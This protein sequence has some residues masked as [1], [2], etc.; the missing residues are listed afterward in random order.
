VTTNDVDT[1]DLRD[2]EGVDTAALQQ[3]MGRTVPHVLP[4]G[5]Q[6]SVRQYPSGFSNLTYRVDVHDGDNTN[7]YV[8]RRPPRGVLTGTAHDMGREFGLL[9][10]LHP[11]YV[12]VPQPV[13]FCED[14]TVL[15]APFYLMMHVDGVILRGATPPELP[16]GVDASRPLLRGLS[17]AF[18]E[19]LA[20]LHAVDVSPAAL[21]T[22]GRP[23]GYVQ[24][25][26]Q[27]WSRRW[28]A[29]HTDDVPAL[30]DVARWLDAHRPPERGVALIHNDFKFDNLVLNPSSLTKVSAILDWEMATL[31]DPLMD[32]GTSLAY[33]I[34]AS[35]PPIFR[36][37]GLGMTALPGNFTRAELVAHYAAV[38]GRDVSDA[39]FYYVFG[40]FKVAVI[41]QQI[42]A[43]HRQGLTS[44]PRF[45]HL[46]VVVA[47][48]GD[49]AR[50]VIARKSL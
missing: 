24:R 29:A 44:D 49:Q 48:L 19:T 16:R 11:L 50:Q 31:G 5:A 35:D 47:A 28:Q 27:G 33:W 6:L 20:T 12:P 1:I 46:G 18:V 9:R 39:V 23:E 4:S 42:Y 30:D 32:L 34:E 36:A 25:Q 43:R 3:W 7:A 8:L 13:A 21:S 38:T 22:L 14:A 2:G 26:V 45:A 37:L 10:V 17:E 15:G 41:A 40:L